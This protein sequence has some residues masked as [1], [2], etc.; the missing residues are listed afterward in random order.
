MTFDL[1]VAVTRDTIEG[2]RSFSSSR[3]DVSEL[4]LFGHIGTHFDLVE[5]EFDAENFERSGLAFDVSKYAS[6]EIGVGVVDLSSVKA[7][8]FVMFHTGTLAKKGYGSMDYFASRTE[9]SWELIERLVESK[10]S[11]IGVD[12]GSIRMPADHPKADRYCADRGT[13]VVENLDNLSLLVAAT[14][15]GHFS[16]GTY[17]MNFKG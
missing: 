4:D 12:M 3:K 13:F 1:S 7:G 15:G 11:M 16:V 17:P 9:L 2:L 5:C 8:D 14:R 10:V 6:G